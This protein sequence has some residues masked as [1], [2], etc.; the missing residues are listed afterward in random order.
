MSV[1]SQG[2]WNSVLPVQTVR[3]SE[4][5]VTRPIRVH[6]IYRQIKVVHTVY[7]VSLR[8][9]LT[10][11]KLNTLP[12]SSTSR[13]NSSQTTP[14]NRNVASRPR[15]RPKRFHW[16]PHFLPTP[17]KRLLRSGHRPHRPQSTIPRNP[18]P[19]TIRSGTNLLRDCKGYRGPRCLPRCPERYVQ[20]KEGCDVDVEYVFHVASPFQLNL[21]HFERD[22]YQPAIHGTT[23]VLKAALKE[24]S[25]KRVVITSSF[26]AVINPNKSPPR[27][28]WLIAGDTGQD[29]STPVIVRE[30]AIDAENDWNPITWPEAESTTV[31]I[32]AYRA[33]KTLAERSAW[34]F[35]EEHH[36]HFDIITILPPLVFGPCIHDVQLSTLN[37]SNSQ[38]WALVSGT[39]DVVVPPTG[40]WRWVDVRD[41]AAAHV[42]ALEP[43]VQ[44]NQRFLV[45][46]GEFTWQRVSCDFR[47]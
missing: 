38:I 27:Q 2:Y 20:C 13:T 36:P 30:M 8:T 14:D 44:G 22:F 17:L 25:V 11:S 7:S 10:L 35:L 28:G 32:T 1:P 34:K 5:G 15:N 41:V 16:R 12:Q 24:K 46:G 33:S 43:H 37:E 45:S 3:R 42:N 39:E 6:L 4:S 18:I 23:G 21:T 9:L 47:G 19:E 26:A 29:T 31:T 40:Q